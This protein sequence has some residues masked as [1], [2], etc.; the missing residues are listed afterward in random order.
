MLS[1]LFKIMNKIKDSKDKLSVTLSRI[2]KDL[3]KLATF[4]FNEKDQGIYRQGFSDADMAARR[5]L[6]DELRS[7]GLEAQMDGAGNV[8]GRLGSAK[9]P[10]VLI[11]SHID[12]VPCGGML[13]GA[14]GVIVGLECLRTI[15]ENQRELSH[16]IELIATS[17]EEGRFGGMFGAQAL[18]G[19]LTP[20]W[21]EQARDADGIY[22]KDAMVGQGLDCYKA[23]HASRPPESIKTYLELH[24]EQG[25]V[26]EAAHRPIGIVEGISGVFKWMVRLIGKADHA[27]TSPMHLRSDAFMGLADFAH[28]IPRIIEE[29][30]TDRSRLTVGKVELKPGY[31]H[32]I[33]GEA[34]FT[35]V[36]RDM[37][38]K[39]M[40][41]L[42]STC[43][44]AL[45]AIAR[46]HRLKFEYEEKSWLEPKHCHPKI[47]GLFETQA[48]TLGYEYLS[49]PSGAGHDAQFFADITPTG[50]IFVP[51]LHG[52]SHAPD[53]WTD[54]KDIE[55]GGNLLL[56]TALSLATGETE[57]LP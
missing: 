30:G 8:S 10:A 3:R 52:V 33:P 21:L 43:R 55:K 19:Q 27:G 11:G 16:P 29:E 50:M 35:L 6:L 26:L 23:L 34:D 31:A 56:H 41:A 46:K 25:P 14:L 15:Q 12:S 2:E 44:K 32:T 20:D 24:I 40:E 18:T 37:D 22:L 36:G 51:S 45:S 9:T 42:A 53:E 5:W 47:M 57:I 28:E 17:E 7:L 38:V 39:V 54:W 49:L 13:D 4:G 48:K 1:K